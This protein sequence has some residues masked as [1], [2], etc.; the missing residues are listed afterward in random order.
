[1]SDKKI[2]TVKFV[3][4]ED[5]YIDCRPVSTYGGEVILTDE[6]NNIVNT[7]V[8]A[9]MIDSLTLNF[10]NGNIT[11]NI[12]IQSIIGV[13]LLGILYGFGNYIFK[14]IPKSLIQKKI[15]N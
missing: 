7:G 8:S 3:E 10:S 15:M 14:E 5:I 9:D 11:N 6:Q 12:V 4:D 2:A 1:M 13:A